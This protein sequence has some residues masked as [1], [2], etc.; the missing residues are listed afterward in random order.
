MELNASHMPSNA[1][2]NFPFKLYLFMPSEYL[3]DCLEKDEIKVCLPK[4]CNDPFEFLPA[5]KEG[6]NPP[7]TAGVGFISFSEEW[8]SSTMWGHY[9]EKHKGVCL[10][11]SFPLGAA[12]GSAAEDADDERSSEALLLDF[13]GTE[14]D[15]QFTLLPIPNQ[16]IYAPLL[17]KVKYW[18][19]R[20]HPAK[21]QVRCIISGETVTDARYSRLFA[22]K[23]QEW[24]YEKEWRLFVTLDNCL[25]YHDGCYF[26]Q[27]LTKYITKVMLG[28]RC[29]LPQAYIQR[30][31]S[32]MSGCKATCV[33]MEPNGNL[34]A[35]KEAP[36]VLSKEEQQK[37]VP[38]V[39]RLNL[40]FDDAQW[41]VLKQAIK[42][43]T[44]GDIVRT[45]GYEKALF[46]LLQQQYNLPES[47]QNY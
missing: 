18:P 32:A 35:V 30:K 39:W 9:A 11:F 36:A 33:K 13:G 23:G 43:S 5:K 12:F 19:Y 40:E 27:G 45:K 22:A 6:C 24:A 46:N 17:M 28:W 31:L 2:T 15:R 1:K 26:V 41:S 20:S 44:T 4:D 16:E 38:S 8:A 29:E 47:T 25:A 14:L 42:E 10:E 7:D 34:F 3:L 21:S 37:A